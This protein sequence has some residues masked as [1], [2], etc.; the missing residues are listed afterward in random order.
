MAPLT[1]GQ[2]SAIQSLIGDKMGTIGDTL[3]APLYLKN[4]FLSIRMG[5]KKGQIKAMT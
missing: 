5:L 1:K 3:N 2:V 4:L